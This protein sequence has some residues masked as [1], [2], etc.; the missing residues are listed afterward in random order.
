MPRPER[1]EIDKRAPRPV[2]MADDDGDG[3]AAAEGRRHV[4]RVLR[5][6]HAFAV[7]E[8]AVQEQ[9]EAEVKRCVVR[10]G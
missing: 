1:I 9:D 8:L 10:V 2:I 5:A 6:P 4:E 7:L 3:A